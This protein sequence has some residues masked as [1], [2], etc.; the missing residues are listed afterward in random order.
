MGIEL[1][2]ATR[3]RFDMIEKL[4]KATLN[5]NKHQYSGIGLSY[6]CCFIIEML[7]KMIT[8]QNLR[9]IYYALHKRSFARP[10]CS[11]H[12]YIMLQNKV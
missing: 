6:K 10:G 11:D 5:Q 1:P 4:L 2:V 12:V 7:N 9:V 8:K 3:H